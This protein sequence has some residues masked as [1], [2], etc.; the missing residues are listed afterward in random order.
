[1]IDDKTIKD[2]VNEAL[3]SIMDQVKDPAE[4]EKERQDSISDEIEDEDVRKKVSSK[5]EVDEEDDESKDDKKLG[6]LKKDKKEDKKFS[7]EI[8]EEMPKNIQFKDIVSQLNALRSGASLKDDKV[9]KGLLKYFD[10]LSVEEKQ[11]LF[12]MMAGFA[13]IM[14]KAGD[15]EDAPVPDDVQ[16]PKEKED[17]ESQPMKTPGNAPIIVGEVSEKS[18]ELMI[19]LENS[20]NNHRC[21]NGKVVSFGSQISISDIEKRIED[22]K[23]SRDSCFKGSEVR[24]SYNGLLKH[25]RV[26]LRAAQKINGKQE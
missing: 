3:G 24:S 18:K 17:T 2:A 4:E 20:K 14:N 12:S 25:L 7:Y 5:S 11:E 22:A 19:F 16:K 21:L 26:Q 10:N 23:S 6:L 13:T 15:V 1:M 9:K 8:P